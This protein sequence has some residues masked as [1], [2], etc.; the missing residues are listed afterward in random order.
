ML[1]GD[2]IRFDERGE[3]VLQFSRRLSLFVW[4]DFL[5]ERREMK[6][7]N[8]VL[9]FGLLV[10]AAATGLLGA[11]FVPSTSPLSVVLGAVVIILTLEG[12]MLL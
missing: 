7:R 6:K 9:G 2:I 4:E 12:F 1:T 11:I 3:A 8:Q 10:A 5:G